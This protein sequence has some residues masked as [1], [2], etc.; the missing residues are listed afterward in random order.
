MLT[1]QSQNLFRYISYQATT[2]FELK[3]SPYIMTKTLK[4]NKA[5]I[6]FRNSND[7]H[8]KKLKTPT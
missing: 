8:K 2:I 6:T 5:K 3:N 7:I 4:L 1:Q